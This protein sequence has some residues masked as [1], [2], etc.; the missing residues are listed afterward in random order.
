MRHCVGLAL[1]WSP[2]RAWS[3]AMRGCTYGTSTVPTFSSMSPKS[4]SARLCVHHGEPGCQALSTQPK[5]LGLSEVPLH[6]RGELGRSLASCAAVGDLSDDV[7]TSGYVFLNAVL[8]SPSDRGGSMPQ[9][10]KWVFSLARAVSM[11][12][13]ELA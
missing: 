12:S 3:K 5:W 9:D 1:T 13:M 11:F 8:S 6:G 10:D 2:V 7:S 4:R